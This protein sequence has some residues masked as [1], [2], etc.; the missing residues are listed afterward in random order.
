MFLYSES[1]RLF[2]QI[3]AAVTEISKVAQY[4]GQNTGEM[5]QGL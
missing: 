5:F 1:Q 2:N 3:H 4:R